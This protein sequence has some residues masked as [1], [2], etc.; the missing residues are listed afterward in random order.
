MAISHP[1]FSKQTR[2]FLKTYKNIQSF[3]NYAPNPKKQPN[4]HTWPNTLV[5]KFGLLSIYYLFT[6]HLQMKIKDNKL[7]VYIRTLGI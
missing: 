7:C 3:S 5:L 2:L 1:P 6:A 4:F